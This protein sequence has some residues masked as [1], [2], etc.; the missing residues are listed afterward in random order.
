MGPAVLMV[1][2]LGLAGCGSAA[3]STATSTRGFTVPPRPAGAHPS[4]SSKMVCA[5]EAQT[6]I[7][8]GLGAQPT[9]VTA[10]TWIDHVYSCQYVYPNATIT[11]T[12]KELDSA[13]QTA[14]Y[15]NDLGQ[16]LGR[17]PDR[18]AIGQGA[19]LTTNG[20]MVV[21]KDWKVLDVDVSQLPASFGQPP[22]SASDVAVS[23]AATILTCWSGA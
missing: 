22:Q 5:A 14:R 6:E 9:H 20:S 19:F 21:R 7:Q 3:S 1:A 18:I 10:A 11:L 23:V 2:I 4:V 15:F 12:V 13:A 17:R 8:L 16:R